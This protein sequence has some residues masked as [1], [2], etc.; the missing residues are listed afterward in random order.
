VKTA[1]SA[2]RSSLNDLEFHSF[3]GTHDFPKSYV[4]AN[5]ITGDVA[6]WL[7]SLSFITN[8]GNPKEAYC[9]LVEELRNF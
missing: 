3:Y 1:V 2:F 8:E 4:E 5:L 7:S 6:D 9:T